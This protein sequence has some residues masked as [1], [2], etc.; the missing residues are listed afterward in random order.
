MQS[1]D[2]GTVTSVLP[3]RE[4]ARTRSSAR[5][6]G[7]APGAN[8][9]KEIMQKEGCLARAGAGAAQPASN[10]LPRFGLGDRR[11][12]ATGGV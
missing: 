2:F 9:R 4:L 6:N 12:G 5:R 10:S 3:T 1:E 11:G 8:G 7:L